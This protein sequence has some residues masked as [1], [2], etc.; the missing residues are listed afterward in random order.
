MGSFY[1]QLSM[2]TTSSTWD[3]EGA[4]WLMNLCSLPLEMQQRLC[5]EFLP[6]PRQQQP[7]DNSL[8]A[9]GYLDTRLVGSIQNTRSSGL[10]AGDHGRAIWTG[11]RLSPVALL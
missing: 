3:D 7:T 11:K 8:D 10:D 1:R 2:H 5:R 6:D 9:R 4:G